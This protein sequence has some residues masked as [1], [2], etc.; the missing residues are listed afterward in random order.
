MGEHEFEILRHPTDPE[1]RVFV[2]SKT[3]K[4]KVD[5][6]EKISVDAANGEHKLGDKPVDP[7]E[8]IE[9]EKK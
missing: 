5:G 3:T 7:S 8:K 2:R 6:S 9:T 4:A 1:P